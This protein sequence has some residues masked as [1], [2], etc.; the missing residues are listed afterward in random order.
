MKKQVLNYPNYLIDENGGVYNQVTKKWLKGS[1]GENGYKYYRL[2]NENE[3]KMFYAHR[4][5]AEA[6]IPNPNGLPVVNHKDENKLNNNIDNLEWVSYSENTK[7]WHN[8]VQDKK[9][10]PTEY[11]TKDLMNEIWK[12][13]GNYLV[14]SCGRIRYAK[15]NNLLRPSIVCGYYKVKL[16]NNGLAKDYLLHK[17]IWQLF[18]DDTMPDD[19]QVIGHIDGNKLNNDIHNLRKNI[20]K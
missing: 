17:L 10:I 14:S 1:I 7:Q 6:Y 11:Y 15:K 3:K 2:S 5:V 12:P 20:I 13:F 4:L 18:S 16:S 8:M 9:Y 19:S